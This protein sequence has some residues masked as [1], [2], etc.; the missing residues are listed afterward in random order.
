HSSAG[1]PSC[2]AARYLA[3]S[4]TVDWPIAYGASARQASTASRPARRGRR[5]IS[6]A[7]LF[8]GRRGDTVAHGASIDPQDSVWRHATVAS[9]V[10]WSP[11]LSTQLITTLSPFAPPLNLKERNGFLDTAGPHCADST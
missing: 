1:L 2:N 5:G 11:L 6:V 7:P 10:R 9:S 8:E 4:S 3:I